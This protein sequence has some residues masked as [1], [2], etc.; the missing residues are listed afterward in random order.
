VTQLE[1]VTGGRA[2]HPGRYPAG[3]DGVADHVGPATGNSEGE[4]GDEQLAV[5]VG[6]GAVPPSGVPVEVVE[7]V[8]ALTC[9]S[10][11]R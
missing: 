3:V 5:A 6:L 1:V 2:A 8:V 9:M 7:A 4:R 11:V 10:L